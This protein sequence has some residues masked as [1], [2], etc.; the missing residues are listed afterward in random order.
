MKEDKKNISQDSGIQTLIRELSRQRLENKITSVK[1]GCLLDWMEHNSPDH[2]YHSMCKRLK[3]IH[4]YIQKRDSVYFLE[5]T[6]KDFDE[7]KIGNEEF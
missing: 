4:E 6:V 5:E 2:I 1:L 7:N 3:E